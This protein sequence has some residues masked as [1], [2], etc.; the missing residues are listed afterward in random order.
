MRGHGIPRASQRLDDV[1]DRQLFVLEGHGQGVLIH[2]GLDRIDVLDLFDGRTGPRGGAASDDA[3]GLEH[4]CDGLG[5][6]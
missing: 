6:S 1:L 5:G 3:R 2:V 4:V